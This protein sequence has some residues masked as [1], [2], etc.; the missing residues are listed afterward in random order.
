MGCDVE[1][2]D[3]LGPRTKVAGRGWIEGKKT[4]F[5]PLALPLKNRASSSLLFSAGVC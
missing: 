3:P 5:P 1:Y 4:N 2:V